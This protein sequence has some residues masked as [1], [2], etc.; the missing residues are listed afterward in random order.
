M[1]IEKVACPHC[2]EVTNA[3]YPKQHS[4]ESISREMK[5]TKPWVGISENTCKECKSVFYSYYVNE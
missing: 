2:G 5:S 3:S 4:F 1:A